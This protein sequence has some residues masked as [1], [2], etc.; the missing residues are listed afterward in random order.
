MIG[1]TSGMKR[2]PRPKADHTVARGKYSGT[3]RLIAPTAMTPMSSMVIAIVAT[4]NDVRS[5]RAS[6][7][8][9]TM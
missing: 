5:P 4:R 1:K 6:A 8:V 3:I 2:Y 7:I 9:A